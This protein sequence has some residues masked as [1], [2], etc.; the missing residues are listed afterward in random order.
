MRITRRI[1]VMKY[2]KTP[3]VI[4]VFQG[5]V[6]SAQVDLNSIQQKLIKADKSAFQKYGRT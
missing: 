3:K 5:P 2:G 1:L 4:E 6:M